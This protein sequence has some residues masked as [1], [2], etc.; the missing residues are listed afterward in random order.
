MSVHEI[1]RNISLHTE[2]YNGAHKVGKYA[3]YSWLTTLFFSVAI[4]ELSDFM[5]TASATTTLLCVAIYAVACFEDL[6]KGC[7]EG[8]RLVERNIVR[9][10]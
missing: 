6:V 10:V 4:G 5:F 8:S 1:H 2:L 3:A 9:I 7:F